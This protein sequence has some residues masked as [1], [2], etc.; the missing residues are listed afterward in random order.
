M[1]RELGAKRFVFPLSV[2]ALRSY[3]R[4]II[5][6]LLVLSALTIHDSLEQLGDLNTLA[7]GGEDVTCHVGVEAG[8]VLLP[9][10]LLVGCELGRGRLVEGEH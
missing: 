6:I 7:E 2:I 9:S 3:L 8:I 10:C 5:L 1:L 4:T